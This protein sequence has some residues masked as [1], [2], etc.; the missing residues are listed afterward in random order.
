MFSRTARYLCVRCTS[1]LKRDQTASALPGKYSD[2]ILLSV[3]RMSTRCVS[4]SNTSTS[5]L[6]CCVLNQP[7][8][9]V[10]CPQSEHSCKRGFLLANLGCERS[11]RV[12][13]ESSGKTTPLSCSRVSWSFSRCSSSVSWW[14]HM[15]ARVLHP[16]S[17]ALAE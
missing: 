5:A 1:P 13:Q 10:T 3:K 15:S 11:R 2:S 4:R 7:V 16:A 8:R 6:T 12:G 17:A 9:I 14:L